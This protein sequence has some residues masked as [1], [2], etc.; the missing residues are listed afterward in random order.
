[1][2]TYVMNRDGILEKM[3]EI[4]EFPI[5]TKIVAYGAGNEEQTFCV[6]SEMTSRGQE[7]CLVSN[8]YQ[9]SYFSPRR[10]LDKDCQPL[11]KSYGIG[12]Y[13]DD[14]DNI[15][16]PQRKV[17]AAIK[18]ANEL[19]QEISN[20]ARAKGNRDRR[21][22]K[23]LPSKYPHLKPIQTNANSYRQLRSN[24]VADLKHNFPNQSFVIRKR[25]YGSMVIEWTDGVTS[26]DV[27]GVV[28]KFKDHKS[29][30]TGDFNDY[31]PSNFNR[32]FGGIDYIFTNRITTTL[33]MHNGQ[34]EI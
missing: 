9:S 17:D 2:E 24:V 31:A 20:T 7:V 5:G 18:R 13:W 11:S 29:D 30:V 28:G 1:M 4:K 33:Q 15:I 16:Y 26:D 14:I 34:E 21:E 27:M 23:I 6:T 8:Y 32:V 3:E 22:I 19:E 25:H 10:Y 12:L